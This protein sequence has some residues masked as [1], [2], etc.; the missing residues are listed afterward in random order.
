MDRK[1]LEG[2]LEDVRLGK[3]SVSAVLEE[4]KHLPYEDLGFA[5]VDHHRALRQGIPE[6]VFAQGKRREQI[7]EI[8][9]RL[10]SGGHAVVITRLEATDAEAVRAR[11]PGL[12]YSE[13][14][15]I[16]W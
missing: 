11:L 10:A 9:A 13:A 7:V 6:V 4:L 5:K 15:R 2:L 8:A 3:R 12:R 14:G 16:G 1:R